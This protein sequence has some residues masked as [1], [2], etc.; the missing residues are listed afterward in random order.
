MCVGRE[1]HGTSCL[2]LKKFNQVSQAGN[3]PGGDF[4][5]GALGDRKRKGSFAGFFKTLPRRVRSS[6]FLQ[7][8]DPP[9]VD[10][11]QGGGEAQGGLRCWRPPGAAPGETLARGLARVGTEAWLRPKST[12]PGPA[13]PPPGSPSAG[14]APPQRA[15]PLSFRLG[16]Q[17]CSFVRRASGIT[18]ALFGVLSG[19]VPP[20]KHAWLVGA[21]VWDSGVVRFRRLGACPCSRCGILTG[22]LPLS[23]G[24]EGRQ[25]REASW[26]RQAAQELVLKAEGKS[27]AGDK[28]HLKPSPSQ[29]LR[30]PR[31]RIWEKGTGQGKSRPGGQ[32]P[33]SRDQ[34]L[35]LLSPGLGR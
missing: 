13:L 27:W 11:L 17:H 16:H 32:D 26:R 15:L 19:A 4:S 24:R 28:R 3:F 2:F 9:W 20:W 6:R 12:G 10:E 1:A 30:N 8:R 31:S 14:W 7:G 34:G 33:L 5:L 23:Y 18:P 25:S 29:D 21:G 22:S 35:G